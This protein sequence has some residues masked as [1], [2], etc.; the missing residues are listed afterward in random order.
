MDYLHELISR[1]PQLSGIRDDIFR[2]YSLIV[3]AYKDN[4]KVL[5]AGNGGSAAD[6]GHIV[7][8]LMKSFVRK[9]PLPPCFTAELRRLDT[10]I[11][12]RLGDS[13][14]QGLPAIDLSAH[15]A[16]ITACVNDMDGDNIYAQQVYG[17]GCK[18]DIFLGISTSGNAKNICCAMITARAKG[19]KTIALTG[20]SGGRVN[21]YADAS[22]I[23][24]ENETYKVQ[25]LHLPI[26]HA[27]CLMIEEHFFL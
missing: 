25:E 1:Y 27:L 11:G 14:Q 23:V 20:G 9:R 22:I 3:N 4:G 19:M 8:E 26:Y 6:A 13:L 16:L 17:Y 18:G 2:A 21:K 24:P 12:E 15:A 7:G 10:E 5:I